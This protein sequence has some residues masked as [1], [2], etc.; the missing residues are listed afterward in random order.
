MLPRAASTASAGRRIV[1]LCLLSAALIAAGC[2]AGPG[3]QPQ[4]PPRLPDVRV[5][6]DGS[7][8]HL[9]YRSFYPTTLNPADREAQA[10]EQAI[11]QL[12]S[13]AL[14]EQGYV[15]ASSSEEAD[16]F[17]TA[18]VTVEKRWRYVPTGGS[19]E[20]A[21][22]VSSRAPAPGGANP[23]PAEATDARYRPEFTYQVQIAFVDGDAY[24]KTGFLQETWWAVGATTAS[25]DLSPPE[26][27][28]AIVRPLTGLIPT[29]A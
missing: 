17:V 21:E 18:R 10:R 8:R 19:E 27:V 25:H 6:T 13:V 15:R 20:P 14:V 28:D 23:S 22:P 7:G 11:L 9:R 12:V 5:Y 24:R 16:F 3:E 1:W 4:P 29:R 2:R 26:L